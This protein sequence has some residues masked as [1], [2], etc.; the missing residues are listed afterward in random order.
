MLAE[1]GVALEDAADAARAYPALWP[2]RDGTAGSPEAAKKAFQRAGGRC[3]T[4][5]LR[6]SPKGDCPAPRR[7]LRTV[8]YQRAGAG[9]RPA[10]AAFDPTLVPDPR[11]WLAA[12]LGPLAR[13]EVAAAAAPEADPPRAQALPPPAPDRPAAPDPPF[14]G[15]TSSETA[16]SETAVMPRPVAAS[17]SLLWRLRDRGG[18]GDPAV[19]VS[20]LLWVLA[21]PAPSPPSTPARSL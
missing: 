14:L 4:F 9:R 16:V 6:E 3:G 11:A 17:P 15:A 1:G 19:R 21:R 8:T 12:R 13:C 5:P 18:G 7:H 20:T 10:A 2:S